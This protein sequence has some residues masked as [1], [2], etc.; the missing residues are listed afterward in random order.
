M[1]DIYLFSGNTISKDMQS[2]IPD[3]PLS[4]MHINEMEYASQNGCV[5]GGRTLSELWH[6]YTSNNYYAV[7]A[8]RSPK[9]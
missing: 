6:L 5:V 2:S 3:L 9:T 7:C 8:Y 1:P 4:E